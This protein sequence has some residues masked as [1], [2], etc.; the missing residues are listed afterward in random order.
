MHIYA[1]TFNEYNTNT[2][3]RYYSIIIYFNAIIDVAIYYRIL[4]YN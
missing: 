1:L 4:F 3:F 2:M